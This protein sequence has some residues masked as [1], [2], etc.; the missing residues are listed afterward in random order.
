MNRTPWLCTDS[1]D[2]WETVC[3]FFDFQDIIAFPKN[4]QYPEVELLESNRKPSQHQWMS[5]VPSQIRL[6][7]E[8]QDQ[9]L[10]LINVEPWELSKG[11]NS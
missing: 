2:E 6:S 11:V 7:R 9:L 4:M 8:D 5:W 1:A 10:F 3:F